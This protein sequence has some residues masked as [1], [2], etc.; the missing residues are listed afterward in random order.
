MTEIF[1]NNILDFFSYAKLENGRVVCYFD[2]C[3]RY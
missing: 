3:I 1:K 2:A